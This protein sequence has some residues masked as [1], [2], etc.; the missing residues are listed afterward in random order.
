MGNKD[1]QFETLYASHN[2]IYRW[3]TGR[4]RRTVD[5]LLSQVLVGKQRV[6]D[7]GC[8]EGFIIR[9]LQQRH[10]GLCCTALDLDAKRIRLTKRLSPDM[11]VV[12]GNVYQLPFP[13]RTFDIVLV[14]ELLEH[15]DDPHSAL[16]QIEHA[17]KRYV[18]CSSPNEPFFTIGNL[19][20]GAHWPRLGRTPTHVNFW[21][22]RAFV[23]LIAQYF[24]VIQVRS[25]FPWT[26]AL[27]EVHC[28][29]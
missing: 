9:R 22:R 13:D 11:W 16:E 18:I 15:L 5:E 2:R 25:C 24:K 10:P 4:F 3:L 29:P 6:L 14:N 20:R 12:E 21:S 17:T 28:Q 26:F 1:Y 7:V 27:C 8:G 19:I 23:K